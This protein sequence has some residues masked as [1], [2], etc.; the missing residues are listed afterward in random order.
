MTRLTRGVVLSGT[1]R[2]ASE[3]ALRLPQIALLLVLLASLVAL[4]QQWGFLRASLPVIRLWADPEAQLKLQLGEVPYD[5]LHQAD[6]VLPTNASVLL[7]TSGEDVRHLEYTTYHRTLYYLAPR[8]VWWVSPAPSDG[9]WESRW[10]ISAPLD[11]N[12]I[13]AI[14]EEK[15]ATHILAHDVSQARGWGQ[16]LASWEG[17]S[18]FQLDESAPLQAASNPRVPFVTGTRFFSL[19]TALAVPIALGWTLLAAVQC[20]GSSRDI[21]EK[22]SLAWVLGA[23]LVSVTMF[24]LGVLGFSLQVQIVLLTAVAVV[25]M[26]LRG[27]RHTLKADSPNGPAKNG[28]PFTTTQKLLLVLLILQIGF[29]GIMA[30]GQPLAVWDSWVTWGMKARTIFLDGAISPAVY[31]DASRAVTHL[32]YPLLL[33]LVQAWIY[34][35]LGVADDRFA[36]L[37]VVLSYCALLG[38]CYTA[39]RRWGGSRTHALLVTTVVA[40]VPHFSLLAGHSLADVPLALVCT[41]AAVY[42][43]FWLKAGRVSDL[44]IAVLTAGLMPWTKREGVVLLFTLGVASMLTEGGSRRAWQGVAAL[45]VAGVILS[46]PWYLSMRNQSISNSNFLPITLTTLQENAAR[47]PTIGRMTLVNLLSLRWGFVWPV[48]VLVAGMYRFHPR[49]FAPAGASTEAANLLPLTAI[50]YLSIMALTYLFSAFVPFE[51]HILSSFYRLA[52]HVLPLSVLWLAY[53]SIQRD[54]GGAL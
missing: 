7:V 27:T 13:Q 29:V 51:Q 53:I 30:L 32:D 45:L 34:G 22:I 4:P 19:S 46:G 47:L 8:S 24:W 5:L 6:T 20:R 11:A 2:L 31:A 3:Q 41:V 44:S 37:P 21:V 52:A 10:W 49:S 12:V 33:P 54:G 50:L 14:A 48:A 25:A 38:I 35:W 26:V 9:T 28:G 18:L 16:P 36:G 40:S 43:M 39:V 42:L 17:G 15:G 1:T 23:G